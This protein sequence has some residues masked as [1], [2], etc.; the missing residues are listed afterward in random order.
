[1]NDN[2]VD[3]VDEIESRPLDEQVAIYHTILE[4]IYKGAFQ[5]DAEENIEFQA[6]LGY[7]DP[8]E[9][10]IYI[11]R[12]E[13]PSYKLIEKIVLDTGQVTYQVTE[14]GE[15]YATHKKI[16]QLEGMENIG[17]GQENEKSRIPELTTLPTTTQKN[18]DNGVVG[19]PGDI[20][21][22]NPVSISKVLEY[23]LRI[24]SLRL[25]ED[26]FI[27]LEHILEIGSSLRLEVFRELDR[28]GWLDQTENGHLVVSEEGLP[29]ATGQKQIEMEILEDLE[30]GLIAEHQNAAE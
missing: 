22:I 16:L 1:V 4:L 26:S 23:L 12:L 27:R 8:T 30:P 6:K 19:L 21:E 13:D 10:E 3:E 5:P 18:N 15:A 17:D 11:S 14:E 29:Y 7:I 20:D 25:C 9:L 2:V 28:R 24:K